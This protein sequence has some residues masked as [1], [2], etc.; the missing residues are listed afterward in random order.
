MPVPLEAGDILES[1]TWA[2]FEDQ[3][4]LN[5]RHWIVNAVT[6]GATLL[7]VAQ[8]LDDKVRPLQRLLQHKYSVFWRVGMRRI[9][10]APTITEYSTTGPEVGLHD[11]SPIPS[12]MTGMVTL[13]T[14]FPGQGFRGRVYIPFPGALSVEATGLPT[15]AYVADAQTFGEAYV[16]VLMYD[17]M[18]GITAALQPVLRA[19]ATGFVTPL[20][21][22]LA[23]KRFAGQHR[24]GNYGRMNPGPP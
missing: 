23:R 18:G 1:V 24:R 14:E 2:Y 3:V 10:A 6:G 21:G 17:D 22:C 8:A 12:Q 20:S 4:G 19:Q 15:A 16:E 13:L 7:N 11:T 9:S 5:V